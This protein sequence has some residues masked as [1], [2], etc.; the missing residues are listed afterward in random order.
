MTHRPVVSGRGKQQV[1]RRFD[2]GVVGHLHDNAVIEQ[3]RVEGRERPRWVVEGGE[4]PDRR[5]QRRLAAVER[6]REAADLYPAGHRIGAGQLGDV[7]TVHGGRPR[8]VDASELEGG[9]RRR[10]DVFRCGYLEMLLA[11]WA[12]VREA[13]VLQP[14][15]RQPNF[16]EVGK[17]RRPKRVCRRTLA[18]NLLERDAE[19]CP[20]FLPAESSSST[21]SETMRL[22]ARACGCQSSRSPFSSSSRARSLPPDL[23]IPPSERTCTRSGT[24]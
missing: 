23:T 11:N 2:D 13:P 16:V 5:V 20:G 15:R 22:R 6:C 10:I 9:N 12:D 21:R 24:M 4:S 1:N 18:L 7:S 3:P 17:C 14:R 19:T 8:T